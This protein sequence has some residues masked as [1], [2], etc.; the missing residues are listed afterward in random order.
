MKTLSLAL[1]LALLSAAARAATPAACSPYTFVGRITDA[2]HVAFDNTNSATLRA[3]A[4]DGTLLASK[5][6]FFRED[7]ARN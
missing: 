6:T 7:S 2:H 5:S 3:Y 4:A 1:S